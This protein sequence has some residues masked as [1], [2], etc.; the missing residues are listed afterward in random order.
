MI[1]A[2]IIAAFGAFICFTMALQAAGCYFVW[3]GFDA[4]FRT[5]YRFERAGMP[6]WIVSL[7]KRYER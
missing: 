1:H 4:R 5:E 3:R 6:G 2:L 7:I